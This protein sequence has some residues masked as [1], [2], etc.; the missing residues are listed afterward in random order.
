MTNTSENNIGM[1]SHFSFEAEILEVLA[2]GGFLGLYIFKYVAL[3][4][5]L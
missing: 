2:V 3:K 4:S 5:G 1:L